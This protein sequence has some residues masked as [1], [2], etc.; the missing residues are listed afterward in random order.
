M[1]QVTDASFH[2][3][4]MQY[5]NV[6]VLHKVCKTL[7]GAYYSAYY[8]AI[9]NSNYRLLK[10]LLFTLNSRATR[11]N[12]AVIFRPSLRSL[13]TRSSFTILLSLWH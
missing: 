7:T 6:L 9:I 10:Q 13:V 5:R 3:E 1:Y 11:F 2:S 12:M 8:S 4:S